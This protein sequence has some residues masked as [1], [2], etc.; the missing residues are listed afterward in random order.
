MST[1]EDRLAAR[2][3]PGMTIA[4]GDG[5]G[6]PRGVYRQLSEVARHTP[7]LRLVLGWLP[8][9][10]PALD[11]AAFAEVRAIMG[12]TGLRAAVSEHA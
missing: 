10:D 9:L 12:G 4:L 6:A 8:K 2:L 11:L 5:V 3:E 7:G 1:L